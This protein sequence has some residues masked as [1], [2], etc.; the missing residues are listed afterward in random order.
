MLRGTKYIFNDV[1]SQVFQPIRRYRLRNL[2]F[3]PKEPYASNIVK[4]NE[5]TQF[6]ML[7][8]GF[9]FE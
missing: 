7:A 4:P 6:P 9:T 8:E 5:V 1:P 2:R 3:R